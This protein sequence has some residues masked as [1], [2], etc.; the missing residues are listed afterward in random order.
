[1]KKALKITGTGDGVAAE[2]NVG[3]AVVRG[4]YIEY[5]NGRHTAVYIQGI[6]A[7]IENNTIISDSLAIKIQP[8]G[9]NL[10]GVVKNNHLSPTDTPSGTI[11][12][13]QSQV[14]GC[15]RGTIYLSG[16]PRVLLH[17]PVFLACLPTGGES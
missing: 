5:Y 11:L 8:Y 1:L 6:G 14:Y 4:N 13:K 15:M 2:S 9:N 7:T 10:G 12:M 3:G 16:N 17:M